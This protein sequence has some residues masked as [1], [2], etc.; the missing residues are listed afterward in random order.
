MSLE[1][2]MCDARG[3]IRL[4]DLGMCVRVPRSP[5]GTSTGSS[6]PPAAVRVKLARQPRR[7]KVCMEACLCVRVVD[8]STRLCVC[9]WV[10]VCRYEHYAPDD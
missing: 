5:E 10:Y 6:S 3:N 7:G 2:L 1:N 8:R 4:I 9:R